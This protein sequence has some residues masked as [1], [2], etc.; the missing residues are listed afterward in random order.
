MRK[1]ENRVTPSEIL[2]SHQDAHV[3]KER[4]WTIEHHKKYDLKY[5]AAFWNGKRWRLHR[6]LLNAQPCQIVDHINGNGLDNRR[7][8]LRIATNAQ[9]GRNSKPRK[10]A[11]KFKGIYLDKRTQKWYAQICVNGKSKNIPGARGLTEIE[12]ARAYNEA[13]IAHYGQFARLNEC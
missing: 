1:K 3:I 2:V 10:G 5:A 12:A 8:N 11:S 9:N 6:Y 7:E 13:A 4:V